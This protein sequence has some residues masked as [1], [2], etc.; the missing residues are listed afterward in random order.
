MITVCAWLLS[1][2]EISP[3]GIRL[4]A[5]L[6]AASV[7]LGIICLSKNNVAKKDVL[8]E[9][10]ELNTEQMNKVFRILFFCCM[11]G[12]AVGV[13]CCAL[14]CEKDFSS[15]Y[16]TI[17]YIANVLLPLQLM[18]IP[19]YTKAALKAASDCA[20]TVPLEN[21]DPKSRIL[22][23]HN[24]CLLV[25]AFLASYVMMFGAAPTLYKGSAQYRADQNDYLRNDIS[26][27]T[28]YKAEKTANCDMKNLL[29]NLPGAKA[30]QSFSIYGDSVTVTYS[31]K[32]DEGK[33]HAEIVYNATAL[34]ALADDLRK[35]DFVYGEET[36]TVLRANAVGCYENFP[37][38]LNEWQIKVTYE[39]RNAETVEKRFSEMTKK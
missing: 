17:V 24:I 5:L 18:F 20:V 39:L 30:L 8:N 16:G 9:T 34:F 21:A 22:R 32:A 33:K 10:R 27:A 28:V 15:T 14:L 38:I 37:Q 23:G 19:A 25:L 36:T 12:A 11:S 1:A 13:V 4:S 29:Q 6:M 26:A 2:L 7:V 31:E 35:I 3:V